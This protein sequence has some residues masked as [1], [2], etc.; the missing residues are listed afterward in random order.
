MK[1]ERRYKM[2][3]TI[4]LLVMLFLVVG[5]LGFVAAEDSEDAIIQPRKV[6]FFENQLDKLQLAFTFNKEA[7]I[8]KVLEMAEKRLAEAELLAD[9][10]P[11]AYEEAQELYDELL[12]EAE[13]ILAEVESEDGNEN[14][15]VEYISKIT[16]IQ[17]RFEAHEG[18]VDEVYTRA[19]E[20]FEANNASDEK[21]ARFEMF[22][23]RALN[24]SGKVEEKI[25][26][27]REVAIK[28]YKS[29]SEMSDEELEE[30]LAQ[31]EEREGL[32][33]DREKRA[34]QSEDRLDRLNNTRERILEN[35][36][37]EFG[38]NA[39]F[40]VEQRIRIES[41]FEKAEDQFEKAEERVRERVEERVKIEIEKSDDLKEEVE[42]ELEKRN[43]KSEYESEYEYESED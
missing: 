7:K 39:S 43:G 33:E 21:I 20:R 15:S 35:L 37:K 24:K 11:E 42:E 23:D 29:L 17:N 41:R 12:A 19:L 27:K 32:A 40:K 4:S 38:E 6:G 2:K 16:R 14:Q 1:N 36:E 13:E 26:E 10:D 30:L 18:H 5:V 34:N 28:E 22:Y 8:N 3:K 31:I 25:L 9:E